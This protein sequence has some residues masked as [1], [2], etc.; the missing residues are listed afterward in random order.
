MLFIDRRA[1]QMTLADLAHVAESATKAPTILLFS[2]VASATDDVRAAIEALETT[3]LWR[4]T[5]LLP[6]IGVV[7]PLGAQINPDSTVLAVS[8]RVIH[9]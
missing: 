1:S 9:A 2:E 7:R 8:G 6:E 5:D 3:G 4:P